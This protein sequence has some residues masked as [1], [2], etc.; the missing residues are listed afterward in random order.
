MNMKSLEHRVTAEEL[1]AMSH[2][3]VR[4]ELVRGEVREMAPTG[5]E[6]GCISMDI[7]ADL[8]VFVR[9]KKLGRVFAAETGFIIARNPDTV[10]APDCAFVRADRLAAGVPRTFLPFAPDLAV[11]TVSPDDRPSRVR[12]KVD[13]W[14]R[15]GV[16][17]L[18]VIDPGERTVTVHRPGERPR[19][20]GDGDVIDG[21]D[22]LPGFRVAVADLWA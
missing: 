18:W 17:L 13:D 14:I 22:V 16:R 1:F 21:E 10:R 6:H 12:D 9:K 20:L 2:D 7:G 15:S 11:E 5:G 4:R 19:V 8:A 3:G